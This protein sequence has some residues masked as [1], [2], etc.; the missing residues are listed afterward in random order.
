VDLVDFL[1]N[2]SMQQA[3][4]LI[5][6]KIFPISELKEYNLLSG[7]TPRG[8]TLAEDVISVE[9]LPHYP[10]SAV[11]G[12][13]LRSSD[14]IRASATTPRRCP[15]GHFTWVNTG[16]SVDRM[17]D[18][19]IMVEDTI[20]DGND[21]KVTRAVTLG[22]NIRPEGEDVAKG[23]VIARKGEK[24]TPFNIPLLIAGGAYRV[25]CLNLPRSIFIPTGDEIVP[26]EKWIEDKSRKE[27]KVPETN[28]YMLKGLFGEWGY[29]LDIHELLP[30]N[31]K[32]IKEALENAVDSYDLVIIGA[33]T[34]KGKRDHS[35]CVIKSVAE[36]IFRGVR[37]KPGRPV[38]VGK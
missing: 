3:L 31:E 29:P 19:V 21:L 22:E 2:V 36:P 11:D 26:S 16:S 4:S 34:A 38:I 33:G 24:L 35:A 37:M 12:Y 5:R 13:A 14:T 27:D 15:E 32:L 10:A 30:D 28:S 20:I 7:V 18:S 17:Y 6:E 9:N 23:Q 8:K 25:Q 1:E